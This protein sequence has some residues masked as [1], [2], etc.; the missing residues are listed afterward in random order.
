MILNILTGAELQSVGEGEV[1]DEQCGQEY[2]GL[3]VEI[4]P[5]EGE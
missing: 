3:A 4:Y 1:D 2:D 5:E